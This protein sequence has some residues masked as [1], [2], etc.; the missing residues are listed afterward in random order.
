MKKN[1][2]NLKIAI[3]CGGSSSESEI[4]LISG[5]GVY[6]VLEENNYR[7]EIVNPSK[8]NDLIKLINGDFDV[9][10]LCLHGKNG[11]DGA[12]QGLLQILN[13]PYTGSGIL[14]SAISIDKS[15]T[16]DI[17]IKNNIPTPKSRLIYDKSDIS[18]LNFN[19]RKYVVK[20]PN[21]GSSIGVFIV[22]TEDQ[23]NEAL[24]QV[25]KLDRNIMIE[26]YISGKEY[27]AAV[28]N[29][30]QN[31]IPLPV[32]EIIPQNNTYDYESK[33]APGG[34]KHICPAQ[35]NDDIYKQIQKYA[36]KAHISL[37][38]KGVSRTDFIVDDSNN[39]WAL[40][41]NTIPGM[42]STSLLPDAAKVANIS[43][44]ELCE[45]LLIDALN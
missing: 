10:F 26:D 17:Y 36:L 11:E 43:Y 28:L 25:F 31:P 3:I 33:Y 19:E 14:A 24:E 5:Q 2:K 35:V 21:E 30:N 44:L 41:T 22:D 23:L 15:K 20:A 40:E 7:V 6:D 34:S 42:T 8:R 4:S 18:D 13:I 38:C 1:I 39:I 12:I 45:L 9:A 32:I 37:G 29:I 16:K 27:T